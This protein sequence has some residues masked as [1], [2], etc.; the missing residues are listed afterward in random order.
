M[1]EENENIVEQEEEGL[2]EHHRF[3]ASPGL[4]PVR[5]DK[6][7][8]IKL[9]G[10]S[11]NKIQNG[12][13][14]GAVK[15][16]GES[17]KPN[18]KL[19][20]G[21]LITIL[22]P[23]PPD[24]GESVVPENI[25]L[26]IR[27]EDDDLLIVYK[28]AGMVVHPGVGNPSGTLVNAL[29]YHLQ[30]KSMPVLPGNSPDRPGLVHRIDK[31]TSGLV[32]IAKNDYTMTHLAKQFFDHTINR[33]Y[34]TIVWGTPDPPVGTIEGNIGRDPRFRQMMTVFADG[35]EGKEAKT[36]YEVLEDLYYISLV[37]CILETGRTHQIRVHMKYI[38]HPVFNDARYG[39]DY[40][41]KG[42]VYTKYKQ[43]VDNCFELCPRQALH[44][45]TIGFEHPTTGKRMNFDSELPPDM[46]QV[47]EKWRGYVSSRKE[48][49]E[50]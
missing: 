48:N 1:K 4:S 19:K 14:A 6:Y 26:D 2:Y 37:K 15:V 17:V 45:R 18:H 24:L 3:L 22:L 27:Y 46:Q 42:T 44:A 12:I 11:R 16:D 28:P 35:E 25:P 33:E 41:R 34:N 43:F 47:L 36:H 5:I 10:I 31:D 21:Q 7:I 8:Q 29:A 13:R 32:L 38:G 39:G 50:N 23:K 30:Q 49:I 9:E 20:A 40:I